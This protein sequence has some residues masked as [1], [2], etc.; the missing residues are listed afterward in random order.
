M[1]RI[2]EFGIEPGVYEHYKKGLYVVTDIITHMDNPN[3]GKMEAIP[4]PLVVYRDVTPVVRHVNGKAQTA[5]QVY[6][7]TLSEFTA[8]VP[9]NGKNVKRFTPK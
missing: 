8:I 6:A 7:R 1:N 5:H 9:H 2:N 3:T 4:D